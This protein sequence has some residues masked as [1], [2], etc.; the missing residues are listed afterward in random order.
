MGDFNIGPKFSLLGGLRYE[1]Y[2]MDYNANF[3]YVTHDVDGDAALFD[4][5]NTVDRNDDD[6]FPNVQIRYKYTD[7][8]DVRMAYTKS[9]IRP[10]YRAIIPNTYYVQ[11]SGSLTGNP[12]LEPTISDN[13][14][15][16]FSFYH[17]KVGLFTVGGFYKKMQDVFFQSDLFYQNLS[18]YNASFPDSNA[19]KEL[20]FK[21]H[22]W[23]A[24]SDKITTF[25]NNPDPAY[26]K[27]LEFEWQTNFWYLP[28]PLNALVLNI[29]Y[30]RIWSEMDYQQIQ[31]REVLYTYVDDKGRIRTGTHYVT[32]DTVRTARL[33]NQADH[34]VNVAAGIDYKGFSGRLSF[35]LQGDVISYIGTR[36]EVDQ[37]TGNIY[38]WDITLQQQLPIEGLSIA[39]NGVNI[40]HN[41]RKEYQKFPNFVGGNANENLYRTTYAPR[42]FELN[43]RYSL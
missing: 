31:N 33:L 24:R 9:I 5:L 7:W 43:L 19:W 4:T 25:L 10:D 18:S 2:N 21:K 11:G 29:N 12:K 22:Q 42:K 26:V 13:F 30:A 35:N 14:D 32:T 39:F 16:I 40:F 36:P 27:G 20:G 37:Y 8:G 28:R 17:N 41:V 38:K 23:P 15:L 3:V 6:F 34:I 1:H